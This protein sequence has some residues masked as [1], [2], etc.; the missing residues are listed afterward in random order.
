[1]NFLIRRILETVVKPGFNQYVGTHFEPIVQ[2][3]LTSLNDRGLLPD[4]FTNFGKWWHKEEEIDIVALNETKKAILFCECKWQDR[5]DAPRLLVALKKK[6]SLVP[7][8]NKERKEYFCIIARSF[9]KRINAKNVTCMDLN[10]LYN[11]IKEATDPV[12]R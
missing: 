2:E 4:R 5:V 6:T 1:M 7:W 12:D 10:D 8:N 11:R 3:V 9:S